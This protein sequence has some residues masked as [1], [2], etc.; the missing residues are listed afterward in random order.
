MLLSGYIIPQQDLTN[1]VVAL[2]KAGNTTELA[3]HFT[4]KVDLAVLD[5]DDV[6]SKAQAE[7]ILKKFITKNKPTGVTI[8]HQGT[9]KLGTQYCIG[10]LSTTNGDFRLSFNMKKQGEK[11]YIQQLRIE[12]KDDDF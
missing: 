4:S 8:L 2:L 3:S 10:T 12:E 1:K 6:F 9:S 5:T 11:F 7:L